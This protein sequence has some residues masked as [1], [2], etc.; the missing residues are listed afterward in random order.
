MKLTRKFRKK[1]FSL[2]KKKSLGQHLRGGFITKFW[3]GYPNLRLFSRK[4]TASTGTGDV[5]NS[6]TNNNVA[7][8]NLEN[9][10][11]ASSD[12]IHS[13]APANSNNSVVADTATNPAIPLKKKKHFADSFLKNLTGTSYTEMQENSAAKKQLP[14]LLPD[15]VRTQV[16]P[17]KEILNPLNPLY[18]DI[19]VAP[20]EI[21]DIDTFKKK[22]H[23]LTIKT[24]EFSNAISNF[25]SKILNKNIKQT[26]IGMESHYF[27]KLYGF[28]INNIKEIDPNKITDFLKINTQN[29]NNFKKDINICLINV[30]SN[31]EKKK[32]DSSFDNIYNDLYRSSLRSDDLDIIKSGMYF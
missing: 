10:A 17:Y 18:S 3:K 24:V 31:F 16:I 7:R 14:N 28:D 5:L 6:D 27:K 25:A 23:E 1:G 21:K 2:K 29:L 30:I 15:F 4:K 20:D 26:F 19:M 12:E 22:F 11:S 32:W 8:A 9:P 13:A